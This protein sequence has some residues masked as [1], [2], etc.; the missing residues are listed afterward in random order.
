[1]KKRPLVGVITADCVQPQIYEIIKGICAQAF[2]C[3]CDI[4]V[5]APLNNFTYSVKP[6]HRL[7]EREIYKLILSDVFDGFLYCKIGSVMDDDTKQMIEMLLKRSNKYVMVT[8]GEENGCF[9]YTQSDDFDDFKYLVDHLI[10]VHG[11]KKIYCVTGPKHSFQAETRLKGYFSAMEEHR[12]YYDSTYYT[13]GDFWKP[14]ARKLA[15]KIISGE[16]AKPDAVVCGNDNVAY[17]LIEQLETAGIH[18]PE[19][20]AVTGYDGFPMGE[21]PALALTTFRRNQFQLGAD[22]L[23]RLYRNITG[24]LSERVLIKAE[25]FCLGHSCGCSS[26]PVVPGKRR[27]KKVSGVYREHM[28]Y[29]DMIF[30]ISQADTLRNLFERLNYHTYML[31]FMKRINLFLTDDYMNA[32]EHGKNRPFRLTDSTILQTV[33]SRKDD[34]SVRFEGDVFPVQQV[35]PLL[36]E[37]IGKPRAVYLSPLHCEEQFFGIASL[38]FGKKLYQLDTIYMD[39]IRNLNAALDRLLHICAYRRRIAAAQ[40]E[41]QTDMFTLAGFCDHLAEH[42]FRNRTFVCAEITEIKRLYGKLGGAKT[43]ILVQQF[44]ALISDLLQEDE[45]CGLVSPDCIGILLCSED[46]AETLFDAL[47]RQLRV[48]VWSFSF[49]FGICNLGDRQ[50]SMPNGIYDLIAEAVNHTMYTYQTQNTGNRELYEK[51]CR[52]RSDLQQHPEY[53]WTI[54]SICK[55]VH[56]SKGYLQKNYKEYFGRSIMDELIEFRLSLAKRLLLETDLAVSEIAAKCGYSSAS[57]FM[58]QFKQSESVTPTEYRKKPS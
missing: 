42:D 16:L 11:C 26:L 37:E 38:S 5:L 14:S 22:C 53:A 25:G 1:M 43:H 3:N 40:K 7:A 2:R 34:Y 50:I 55:S 24:K 4:A 27:E 15:Q 18:V 48:S 47:K 49:S 23:R 12:L 13:Y 54:D 6:P 20:I 30:D 58:K 32:L 52:L 45:V 31:Y 10:E 46:R 28:T 29:S 17:T 19:D 57:Y 44:G 39:Y 8:D 41:Q 35:L 9:D 36:G 21:Y 33:Y 51:L 56:V